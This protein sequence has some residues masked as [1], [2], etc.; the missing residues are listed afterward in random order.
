MDEKIMNFKHAPRPSLR[1][2]EIIGSL[3]KRKLVLC[4]I[5]HS[6]VLKAA[7]PLVTY[8]DSGP[9]SALHFLC[10]HGD[11]SKPRLAHLLCVH[12]NENEEHI[13]LVGWFSPLT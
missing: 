6:G 7:I 8:E 12:N 13:G 10:H 4:G 2:H 9:D 1:I 11:P 5:P 3:L